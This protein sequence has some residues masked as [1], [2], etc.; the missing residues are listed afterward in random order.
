ML[1]KQM[2][3]ME[4]AIKD[5][6]MLDDS[7]PFS[8]PS[9]PSLIDD[10][11][12]QED[13]SSII[14]NASVVSCHCE[15]CKTCNTS[16]P[17]PAKRS[18]KEEESG[19]IA[20]L[21]PR[22]NNNICPSWELTMSRGN[23]TLT[24]NITTYSELVDN[25]YKMQ[26]TIGLA[27]EIPSPVRKSA[28]HSGIIGVLNTIIRRKYGKTHCKNVARSISLFITPDLS[29][30]DTTVV[31]SRSLENIQITTLKLVHAYLS[32]QHLK[33]LAIHTQTF[34]RL[35]MANPSTMPPAVMAMCATICTLRCKHIAECLTSI[36]LVEYGKFYF[37]RARDSIADEFD[38]VDLETFTTFT[39]MATYLL[40]VSRRKESRKYSA[41][42]DRLSH[43]LEP[44]YTHLLKHSTHPLEKGEAIHFMRMRS[45][46]RRVL[47]FDEVSNIKIPK[48]RVTDL[49]YCTLIHVDQGDWLL[50]EDDSIQERQFADMHNYILQLQRN[51]YTASKMAE[52]S[53]FH[54]LVGLIAHQ[55]EMAM[56]HWYTVIIPRDYRLTLPLF[57]ANISADEYYSTLERECASSPIPALTTLAIYED[58]IIMGQ[59]Y[60]P[61]EPP[62][63]EMDW[64]KLNQAWSEPPEDPIARKK[65]KKRIGKL[66]EFRK[67]IEFD[68][69]DEEYLA[70]LQKLM[71]PDGKNV[72]MI[73]TAIYA[74]FNTV[75]IIQ[76]LRSRT[77]DCHF[78]MRV[79]I[80]AWQ[81]MLIVSKMESLMPPEILSLIPRIR[82]DLAAIMAVVYDE[83]ALQPFQGQMGEYVAVMEN[84][85]HSQVIRED[86]CDCL[87]CPNA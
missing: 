64:A 67:R 12:S 51:E 61:K 15:L 72:N 36:S 39:F 87:A 78:D 46:L 31:I 13:S 4:H 48:E 33:Q 54:H 26:N 66:L 57:D 21:V 22:K 6:H 28:F 10:T 68:G 24:T 41:M 37:E 18:R 52:S 16:S 82:K 56:R 50:A 80:N 71:P 14:C 3:E 27:T 76:Y 23:F 30:I 85:L 19:L 45:H 5:A 83:L 7:S 11:S 74:A 32:C 47:T 44:H 17:P 40:A 1:N 60:L 69:T 42:A 53:D 81:L 73:V 35:Y 8:S 84:D 38:T 62:K 25:I 65:W 29:N 59:S 75:R 55:V 43:L 77:Q 20:S 79:L 86:D 63:K 34:I 58:Y 70:A 49:P 2:V 9:P